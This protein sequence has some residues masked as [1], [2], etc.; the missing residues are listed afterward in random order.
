MTWKKHIQLIENKVLKNVGVLYKT[1]KLINSK[2]L[3]SICFS[4]IHS[5]IN[6]ISYASTYALSST[7]HQLTLLH[8]LCV[9]LHSFINYASTYTLTSTMHQLT[10]L[11]Q[12]CINLHSFINYAS[13]YTLSSTMYQLTLL[14]QLYINL[15]SFINYASTYAL[16]STMQILHWLTTIKLKL[17]TQDVHQINLLQVI[18][19]MHKIKTNSFLRIFLH[20]F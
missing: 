20:Q 1:K 18:M 10:L 13:T 11:H 19:F 8:Q 14:H 16:L 9:N 6:Y 15:H 3:R 4:F 12:L 7:M 17:N 2:C 5:Y